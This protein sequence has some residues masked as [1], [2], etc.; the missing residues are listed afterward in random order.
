MVA[1]FEAVQA[2]MVQPV[3][4]AA[5]RSDLV[6]LVMSSIFGQNAP[7]I[8]ATE[9]AYEEMWALDVAVMS[10]YDAGASTVVSALAP[11]AAPVQNLAGAASQ[12][13]AGVGNQAVAAALTAG[14]S[15]ASAQALAANVGLANVGSGDLG[16]ANNG[17]AN[18]GMLERSFCRDS[19]LLSDMCT[20]GASESFRGVD[21]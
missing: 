6:S 18:I 11:F 4:V 20:P 12:A 17:P 7:A 1:E 8:A 19:Y 5:N 10:G 15:A 16:N 14:A 13:A 2:A 21:V 3:L 9:A